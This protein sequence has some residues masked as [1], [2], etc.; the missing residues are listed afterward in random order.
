MISDKEQPVESVSVNC[1][2]GALLNCEVKLKTTGKVV[3]LPTYEQLF[4]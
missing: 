4:P 1:K 3:P 2:A